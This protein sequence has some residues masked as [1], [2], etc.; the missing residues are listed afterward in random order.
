M[1]F[2]TKQTVG[3]VLLSM[4]A[5]GIVLL[6]A[7]VSA[8]V[9]ANQRTGHSDLKGKQEQPSS[10]EFVRY[11]STKFSVDY[12]R[13]WQ[14][15]PQGDTGVAIVGTD[16]DVNMPIRT[17]IVMLRE[18]PQTAVPQRLDQIV[19]EA[20]AVERYTLVAVDGQ[21]GFRVWY[22]PEAGQ[23]ALITFVG[24]GNEQTV[25]LSSQYAQDADAE[26]VVTQIHESF[27]N[28]SVAQA[29]TP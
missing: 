22:Q 3:K 29:S 13:G 10:G 20:L 24:Y 15:D 21:S 5:L 1:D 7:V 23:Q 4:G 27:V 26:T 17:D 8:E 25:V 18:D 6:P 16:N 28:H 12:P 11:D 2:D 14:V 19:T 9:L